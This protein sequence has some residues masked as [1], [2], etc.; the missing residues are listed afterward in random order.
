VAKPWPT[1]EPPVTSSTAPVPSTVTRAPS[2]GPSPRFEGTFVRERLIDAIADRLGLDRVTARRRNLITATRRWRRS[3]GIR[4]R[5][6]CSAVAL[7]ANWSA[8]VSQSLSRKA[9]W[10]LRPAAARIVAPAIGGILFFEIAPL[11]RGS[12]AKLSGKITDFERACG[13]P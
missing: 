8:Q 9:A 5:L 11:K 10:M 4:C 13:R 2:S 1:A 6:I 7:P 12:E 3:A